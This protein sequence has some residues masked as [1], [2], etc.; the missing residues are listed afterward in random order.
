MFEM[1]PLDSASNDTPDAAGVLR[2]SQKHF[3]RIWSAEL[4][5]ENFSMRRPEL[6]RRITES[7]PDIV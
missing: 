7:I 4:G 1:V 6:W 5:V 2:N 3:F